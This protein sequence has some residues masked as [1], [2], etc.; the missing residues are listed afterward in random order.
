MEKLIDFKLKTVTRNT[1][2]C[3]ILIK[4]S[5]NQEDITI[6]YMQQIRELQN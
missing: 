2:G 3:Y 1:E 5:I 4:S 6:I